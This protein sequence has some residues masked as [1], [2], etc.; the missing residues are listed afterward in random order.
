LHDCICRDIVNSQEE[1]SE[2]PSL[3]I[4]SDKLCDAIRNMLKKY[5]EQRGLIVRETVREEKR[6][7]IEKKHKEE[8]WLR[9]N[10]EV[11]IREARDRAP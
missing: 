10:E 11:Q 2:V 1:R 6:K 4:S 3:E 9:E 8:N 5:R 7:N